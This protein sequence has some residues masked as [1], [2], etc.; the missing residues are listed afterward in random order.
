MGS[1]AM[2]SLINIFKQANL[3]NVIALNTVTYNFTFMEQ[4]AIIEL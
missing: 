2:Q 4:C 3:L 1:A